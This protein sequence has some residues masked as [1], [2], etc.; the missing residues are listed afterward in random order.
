MRGNLRIKNLQKFGQEILDE[1]CG[2]MM[3]VKHFS[4]FPLF[5]SSSVTSSSIKISN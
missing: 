4:A 1:M 5:Q 2:L 3:Y